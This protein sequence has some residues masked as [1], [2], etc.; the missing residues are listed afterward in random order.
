VSALRP[1]PSAR[2]PGSGAV[3]RIAGIARGRSL[4]AVRLAGSAASAA[5]SIGRQPMR[6]RA[7]RHFI[8]SRARRLPI[9]VIVASGLGDGAAEDLAQEV[10]RTQLS[11]RSFR[12]LFVVDSADFAPFR[13]RGY[14]VERVMPVD[15]LAAVNPGDDYDEYLYS[16]VSAIAR[17]Y[18]VASVVPVPSGSLDN[19]RGS[20]IRLVGTIP[21]KAV[22]PSAGSG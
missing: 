10:E 22:P 12:P 9:I 1:S 5:A 21:A 20:L 16:R 4:R 8:D 6:I 18:H 13:R 17:L 11:T 3:R 19:L 7:G 2:M 14:V 15:E